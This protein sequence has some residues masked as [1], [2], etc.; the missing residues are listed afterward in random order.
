MSGEEAALRPFLGG[1]R[2]LF[3]YGLLGDVTARLG[4]LGI[5]YMGAQQEWLRGLGALPQ[6]VRVPTGAPVAAN[7]ARIRAALAAAP[8]TP[9]ALLVA[10]SKGG[11]E[12]LAALMDPAA[13]A[14]CAGMVAFQSPFHGTLLADLVARR[15]TWH[16]LS[17]AALALLGCG[18]G[19]GLRDLTVPVREAWMAAH[20]AAI[21]ALT[22]RLPVVS[23]GTVLDPATARAGRDHAY[24]L[25][26]TWL[27][28]VAGPNDGLVPI[29]STRLPG[30]ARHLESTGGHV[31]LVSRGPGRD[32][33]GAL[34]RALAAALA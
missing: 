2:V 29:A 10:H 17:R 25:L 12:A 11:L 5:D 6:V 14:R 23:A 32:P 19:A 16:G 27:G 24:A 4:P 1:R 33:V 7:A 15:R 31:A 13:A 34:R 8:G 22:Q 21:V 18:D 20:A 30:A 28:R 9:P 26:T 3:A